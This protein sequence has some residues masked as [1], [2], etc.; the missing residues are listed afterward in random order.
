M[1]SAK[2]SAIFSRMSQSLKKSIEIKNPGKKRTKNPP[3][4]ALAASAKVMG[5]IL[6]RLKNTIA[7]IGSAKPR[8]CLSFLS[9][10]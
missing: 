6:T 4:A 9:I 3:N 7:L 2:D 1:E 10:L 5:V 8:I